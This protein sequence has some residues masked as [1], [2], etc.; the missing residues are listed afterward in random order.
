MILLI[1]FYILLKLKS[2]IED[3]KH[4]L[5]IFN[6]IS[7]VLCQ[8]EI[9]YIIRDSFI[10]INCFKLQ[11]QYIYL[12]FLFY[13]TI[14]YHIV[15]NH[16]QSN[17]SFCIFVDYVDMFRSCCVVEYHYIFFL[18]YI[19]YTVSICLTSKIVLKLF[20]CNLPPTTG[21]KFIQEILEP[22]SRVKRNSKNGEIR[23]DENEKRIENIRMK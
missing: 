6:W 7:K 15:R 3:K 9:S 14:L 8:V 4:I 5:Y 12:L 21:K 1:L 11:L 23:R 18:P 22:V 13:Y 2:Y 16:V 17:R 19:D 20:N 10:E